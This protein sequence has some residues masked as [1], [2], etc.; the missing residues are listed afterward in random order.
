MAR[1]LVNDKQTQDARI[2]FDQN[3]TAVTVHRGGV[4]FSDD[5]AMDKTVEFFKKE[6]GFKEVKTKQ[7]GKQ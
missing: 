4:Y 1:L 5:K 6:Y 3:N 2:Y 7:G